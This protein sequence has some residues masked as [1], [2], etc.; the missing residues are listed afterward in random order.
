MKK[1]AIFFFTEANGQA[2]P[3]AIH[4][5]NFAFCKVMPTIGR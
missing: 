5:H 4:P 2:E 1:A 3:A